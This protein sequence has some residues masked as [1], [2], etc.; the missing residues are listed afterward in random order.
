MSEGKFIR[1]EKVDREYGCSPQW[2]VKAKKA[3]DVLGKVMWDFCWRQYVFKPEDGTKF[4][5]DC[6]R[7]IAQ[8]LELATGNLEV[9][10]TK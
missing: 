2:V 6:L 1:F 10:T 3:D 8:F 5:E 7:D 4:E 9:K